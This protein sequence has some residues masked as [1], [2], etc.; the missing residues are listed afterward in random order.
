MFCSSRSAFQWEHG[1]LS[2]CLYVGLSTMTNDT[3][4]RAALQRGRS[5]RSRKRGTYKGVLSQNLWWKVSNA[6]AK[7]TT[8]QPYFYSSQRYKINHNSIIFPKHRTAFILFFSQVSICHHVSFAKFK[9][10]NASCLTWNRLKLD[11]IIWWQGWKQRKISDDSRNAFTLELGVTFML[12]V[13]RCT[14]IS[15]W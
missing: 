9:S 1:Q 5:C 12:I 2:S 4:F 3:D 6:N 7:L 14:C 8:Q 13:M 10:R 11:T 15:L